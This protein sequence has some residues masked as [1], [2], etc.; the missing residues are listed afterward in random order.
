MQGI[1]QVHSG[2]D[3][4][5]LTAPPGDNYNHDWRE[6]CYECL[7]EISEEGYT[8]KDRTML[9]YNGIGAGNNFLGTRHDG[10]FL[11][12]T[13]P[14]AD[15]YFA[16]V[17]HP[18]ANTPRLDLQ[19]TVKYAVM[20][21]DSAEKAYQSSVSANSDLPPKMRRTITQMSNSAGGA[22]TYI[23][24]PTSEMRGRIYNKEKQSDEP[25]YLR[26]WRYEVTFKN[27]KA[28]KI[29]AML[30]LDDAKRRYV[31]AGIVGDWFGERGVECPWMM[32]IDLS[33]LPLTT[34]V[35]P[36]HKRTLDW[37]RTAV[38]PAL[39]KLARAGYT[40]AAFDALDLRGL[41]DLP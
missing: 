25:E 23:G 27:K 13:G 12:L 35:P 21:Q 33:P 36:D 41:A 10:T 30:P 6:R 3:W 4:L 24:A 20:P 19:V 18:R 14:R 38:R 8:L 22:T 28:R 1:E 29:M 39:Y 16:R 26:C 32:D 11:Q 7:Q 2:A 37:L 17:W 15:R 31:V 5:N 40:E 34:S 9:G